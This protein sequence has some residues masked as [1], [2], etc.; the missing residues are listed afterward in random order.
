MPRLKNGM[1]G[2]RGRGGACKKDLWLKVLKRSCP[3][4]GVVTQRKKLGS[5]PYHPQFRAAAG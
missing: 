5:G 3:N 4:P 2:R 1:G